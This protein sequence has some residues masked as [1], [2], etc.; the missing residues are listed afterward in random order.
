MRAILI[1]GI[2]GQTERIR[3]I[4]YIFQER[5]I[6]FEVS[7]YSR[8]RRRL[9]RQPLRSNITSRPSQA[10]APLVLRELIQQAL[11]FVSIVRLH[12]S[13]LKSCDFAFQWCSLVRFRSW[14]SLPIFKC[15]S[16]RSSTNSFQNS[17]SSRHITLFGS[18][19]KML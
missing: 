19:A 3:L 1:Y 15:P 11:P 4:Q 13:H 16:K 17:K 7:F 10:E 5:F 9:Y 2:Y 8:Q 12:Q 6:R 18:D 14:K